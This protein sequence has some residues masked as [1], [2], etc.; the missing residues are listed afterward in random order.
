MGQIEVLN[1]LE[2]ASPLS[3]NQISSILGE[4]NDKICKIL[5]KLID[6]KEIEFNEITQEQA[7][8]LFPNLDIKRRMRL[9]YVKISKK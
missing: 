3:M 8:K 2:K 1:I 5:K 6:N 9:Y 4:R 7:A